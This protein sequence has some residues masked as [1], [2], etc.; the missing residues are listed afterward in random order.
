[1]SGHINLRLTHKLLW[2]LY[3]YRAIVSIISGLGI[4]IAPNVFAGSASYQVIT[5]T[6]PLQLAGILWL[7]AGLM[8]AGA[9][10]KLLYK[11]AR[12]GIAL[13]IALYFLWGTG[14]LT[15]NLINQGS[16]TAIFAVLAYYSL[17]LTS[18]FMLLE[19]PINPETAIRNKK[20]E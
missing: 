1:M 10:W 7:L 16:P 12:L 20:K 14:I 6:V 11:V 8:I 19:P 5:N 4:L 2:R 3:G 18:F 15:N 17:S 9:L 13:S